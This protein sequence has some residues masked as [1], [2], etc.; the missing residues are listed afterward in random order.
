MIIASMEE[1]ESRDSLLYDTDFDRIKGIKR[2]EPPK[3][4]NT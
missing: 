2:Q 4:A 1:Q 3:V